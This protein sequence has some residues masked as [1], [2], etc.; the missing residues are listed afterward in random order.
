MWGVIL[1]VNL[2]FPLIGGFI[3]E[4]YLIV[5][6]GGIILVAFML[7]YVLMGLVHMTLFFKMKRIMKIEVKR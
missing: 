7:Q 2:G 4:L 6:L 5:I 1:I 3:S